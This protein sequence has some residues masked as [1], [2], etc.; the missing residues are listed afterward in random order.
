[1]LSANA[2]YATVRHLQK[3]DLL[4]SLCNSAGGAFGIGCKLPLPC[5][6]RRR[7]LEAVGFQKR[8]DPLVGLAVEKE[9]QAHYIGVSDNAET[10]P[11]DF[12]GLLR[13]DSFCPLQSL[14]SIRISFKILTVV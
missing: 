5:H 12:L 10:L 3:K 4:Y 7:P 6:L 13:W 14:Q 9:L 8:A 1:M 2:E 11:A